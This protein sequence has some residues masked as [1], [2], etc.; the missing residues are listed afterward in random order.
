MARIEAMRVAL[1]AEYAA[2]LTDADWRDLSQDPE[3]AQMVAEQ[4]EL[5]SGVLATHGH[6]LPGAD[7]GAGTGGGE[8]LAAT[9]YKVIGSDIARMQGMGI[10]TG[11]AEYTE[12]MTMPGMLFARTLR[13]SY[14]HAKILNVDTSK[15]E[16]IPGVHLILH[17]GN[18]PAAYKDVKLGAADPTRFLFSEEV[19]EVGAPIAV[20]A[21]ETEHIADDAVRQ[22]DVKYQPLPASLDMIAG[23]KSSTP[24]QFTTKYDGTIVSEDPPFIRGDPENAHADTTVHVVAAKSTEQ[25]VALEL[26]NSLTWWDSDRLNMTYTSQWAHGVRNSLADALKLPQNKVHVI[27]PGYVGSGYGYRSGIDLQ[28]VHAAILSQMTGR[29]IKWNYTRYEDFVTRTHRPQFQDD[30]TLG[31]N[32]DGTIVSGHFI[33]VANVGAQRAG[34]A[35]GSWFNMQEL[36]KI[37]NLKLEAID[38]MTNS[39]KSGPYRCVSH[40]NGTLALETTME[41]AAYAIGMDPVE[42]RLKNLNEVGDPD[43]KKPF[44]NPGIRDCITQA[45]QAIGWK[46]NWHAPK[47]K[48]VRPGVYHG[49]GLAAHACS[50]G[51]GNDNAASGQVIVNP[52]GT[53]Q[54]I[55][56]ANDIGDG[57][58]TTMM[59]IAAEALGVPLTAMS[60]TP[61]VDTDLTTDTSGTFGSQQTN[62]GGRGMHEAALDARKQ[63]LDLGAAK[64]TADAK[65]QGQTVT[66]TAADVDLQDGVVFLKSDPSKKHP[67]K[68]VVGKPLV[69]VARYRPDNRW[70]RVAWAAHAVEVE[71]DTVTGSIQITKYVAAHDVGKA[72]NPFA[73]RQQ[74]EGG[75]V[76][77]AG[78]VLT[79]QLLIDSATGLPLNPN[80]L[81]YKPL[82]IKD[83][84]L[85]QAILVEHPKDYG[86]FGVHG[87]GEPPM[88]PGAPAI[89]NAVYNAIGVWITEMPITRDKVLAGLKG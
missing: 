66:L 63:I 57:Q 39:Y 52:D 47:T 48:Q 61:Y 5:I 81:D 15:A 77:A 76:M 31:V 1:D 2:A 71:V 59:M 12:H 41:R 54:C 36:Y 83:A 79:E 33:V 56:A 44:S 10:V 67:L 55:S 43:T 42:F 34:A 45:A 29:P 16:K 7:D 62:T 58:R 11:R 49:I 75:V 82:S 27:Q 23:M 38:V 70:T 86:V 87:L 74:I 20:V 85:A 73:A 24:K 50:H 26:T 8:L 19:F 69:G 14:P 25:H 13:S 4:P 88:S 30:M 84:P 40:P 46:Q 17:R 80:L 22:I 51:A 3:W 18:L 60:I 64:F 35:D 89:S 32:K 9:T 21:A 65:K 28:E 78:A 6:K 68:D 72:I 53:V 37:P